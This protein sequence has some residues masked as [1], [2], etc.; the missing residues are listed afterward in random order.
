MT[1]KRF[2]TLAEFYPYYLDE[3]R[4]PGT[5]VL[6]FMGTSLFLLSGPVAVLTGSAWWILAGIVAAYLF[7]WLGHFFV[8]HNRPATFTYPWLS[9]QADFRL[10]FDL[11]RGR[12]SFT[13]SQ[14]DGAAR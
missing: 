8:E 2:E 12:E 5:R 11:L 3:H 9:L 7:A 4:K 1:D 14:D 13:P 10:Y 6:H